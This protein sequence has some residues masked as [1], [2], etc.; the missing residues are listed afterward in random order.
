MTSANVLEKTAEA[1]KQAGEIYPEALAEFLKDKLSVVDTIGGPQVF[2]RNG[3]EC[4]SLDAAM[5]QLKTTEEVGVLFTEGKVDVRKIGVDMFQALRKHNREVLG[6]RTKRA[7]LLIRFL[8]VPA[9]GDLKPGRSS[10]CSP[11]VTAPQNCPTDAASHFWRHLQQETVVGVRINMTNT[12]QNRLACNPRWADVTPE[13]ITNGE[14]GNVLPA[15]ARLLIDT[16]HG[17][18]T[19]RQKP[20]MLNIEK[21]LPQWALAN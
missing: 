11:D 4:E 2:V 7:I 12:L 8:T 1:A 6:L 17:D 3:L 15:L 21:E 13:F 10:F 5:A 16:F 18:L 19:T 9:V 14:P 20:I